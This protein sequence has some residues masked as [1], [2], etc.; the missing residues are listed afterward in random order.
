MTTPNDANK[1]SSASAGSRPVAWAVVY[2]DDI[3]S[4]YDTKEDCERFIETQCRRDYMTAVPLYRN[5]DSEQEYRSLRAENER[6][7]AAIRL[8]ADQDATLSVRNGN[9][10]VTMDG[11]LTDAERSAIAD[12]ANSWPAISA[13]QA[14]T[15]RSLLARCS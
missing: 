6:L 8:L 15:L 5:P 1:P 10:T 13:N 14:A 4:V 2:F 11:T 9:V 3:D 7:R 12:A